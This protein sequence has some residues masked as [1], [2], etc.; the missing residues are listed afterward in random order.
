MDTDLLKA[1]LAGQLRHV[2][3]V[4]SGA[5]IAKGALQTDQQGAFIQI[6]LGC[7]SWAA[8]AVWSWW[9]KN[10]QAAVAA[11]LAKLKGRTAAK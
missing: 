3:T 6:G 10:G 2:L 5:L 1:F 4:V 7:A 9:Q 8:V 11:E